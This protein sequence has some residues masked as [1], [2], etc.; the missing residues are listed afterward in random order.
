VLHIIKY[1]NWASGNGNLFGTHRTKKWVRN[2]KSEERV[3]T[4]WTSTLVLHVSQLVFSKPCRKRDSLKLKS[5][6]SK[7]C[8]SGWILL[9]PNLTFLKYFDIT[10]P[11]YKSSKIEE[12]C[13]PSKIYS[14]QFHCVF[15]RFSSVSKRETIYTRCHMKEINV[16]SHLQSFVVV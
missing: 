13:P 7:H 5:M 4:V 15:F 14:I 9:W 2:W 6:L 16:P 1:L 11:R 10:W 8:N 3:S 12:S